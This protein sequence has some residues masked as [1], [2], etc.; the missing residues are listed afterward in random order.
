MERVQGKPKKTPEDRVSKSHI[1]KCC[2][3]EIYQNES[4]FPSVAVSCTHLLVLFM[5]HGGLFC[6]NLELSRAVTVIIHFD[7][8]NT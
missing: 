2:A 4:R 5:R 6:N 7:E 8:Q 3:T 1:K